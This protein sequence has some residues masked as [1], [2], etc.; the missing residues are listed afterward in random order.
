MVIFQV[1]NLKI[2]KRSS[3]A[4]LSEEGRL[5]ELGRGT[6]SCPCARGQLCSERA[7]TDK[8]KR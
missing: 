6:G 8:L 3:H 2:R 5:W 1:E 7:S 4:W